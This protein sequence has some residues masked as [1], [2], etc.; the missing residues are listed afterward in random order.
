[1]IVNQGL[2]RVCYSVGPLSVHPLS[3]NFVDL[4][5]PPQGL[6]TG[7][8]ALVVHELSPTPHESVT[9]GQNEADQSI[10]PAGD[11]APLVELECAPAHVRTPPQR[12]ATR[13]SG[14]GREAVVSVW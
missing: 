1:M 6:I 12:S 11:T 7:P 9:A 5:I 2:C 13:L 8:A 4:N 10:A 3:L 14:P